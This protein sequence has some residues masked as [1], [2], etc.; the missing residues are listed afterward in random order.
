MEFLLN[1]RLLKSEAYTENSGIS[2]PHPFQ[3]IIQELPVPD[4]DDGAMS[5]G[6]LEAWDISNDLFDGPGDEVLPLCMGKFV[7]VGDSA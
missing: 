6:R 7:L 1:V 2:W 3:S 5:I 4:I